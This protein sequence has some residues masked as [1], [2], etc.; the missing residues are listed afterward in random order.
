MGG[1]VLDRND[2]MFS[3][4]RKEKRDCLAKWIDRKKNKGRESSRRGK[5]CKRQGADKLHILIRI[6]EKRMSCI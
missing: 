2:N 5:K 4:F 3:L 6:A 1:E